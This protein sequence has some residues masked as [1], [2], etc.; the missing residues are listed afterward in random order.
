[1]H[2]TMRKKIV[3]GNWKMNNDL[4][5]ANTLASEVVNMVNDELISDTDVVM[6]IPFVYL[7]KALKLLMEAIPASKE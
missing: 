5:Q 3:A 1:M 7:N 2:K 4:Q 6:C